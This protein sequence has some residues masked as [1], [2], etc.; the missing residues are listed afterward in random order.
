[1]KNKKLIFVE[2][3]E[4]NFEYTK[5]YVEKFNLSNFKK[6]F[7]EGVI[8]TSSETE[9][10]LLEPWIQWVTIHTGLSASEHGIFR[11]GD[12]VEKNNKDLFQL[13]E[14]KGFSVGAIMP[15]NVSNNLKSPKYFIPDAWTKTKTDGSFW[16]KILSQSISQIIIN[17]SERKISIKNL[18]Y[19]FLCFIKFSKK[20]NIL[21]YIKYFFKGFKYKYNLAIFLDLF[22]HD[23]HLNFIKKYKTDFSTIF[24]NCAAHIQHHYLFN[25][26]MLIDDNKNPEWYMPKD[27]DPF[28]DV[29]SLYD[30]IIG[31]YL[32]QKNYTIVI[33]TGLSQKKY[34][35]SKFYYRLKDHEKFLRR[36]NID[37]ISVAPRMTRDFLIK[38][39]STQSA[40][41]AEKILSQMFVNDEQRLFNTIDNRG[42]SLFVTLTYPN[43]IKKNSFVK[44]MGEKINLYDETVF[45]ALKNGMHC[46]KGYLYF[47][48]NSRFQ[49]EKKNIKHIFESIL[50]FYS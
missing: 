11:L 18:F 2:L 30:K 1:M 49:F 12:I 40:A 46:D 37:F 35:S 13:V 36:A 6:I 38:F 24:F 28:L 32:Q 44:I 5:L 45:V 29:L 47:K 22:I 27:K 31:D 10:S 42:N 9:Y 48:K 33:S 15:M 8:E 7:D 26:K 19:F 17:N 50:N 23:L 41:R 3:N 25:S 20:K 43:E 34:D 14:E 39:Q 4:L 16:S 21:I